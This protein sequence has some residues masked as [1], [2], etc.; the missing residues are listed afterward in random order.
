MASVYAILSKSRYDKS[1]AIP[2][3]KATKNSIGSNMPTKYACHY[4]LTFATYL[5]N[6]QAEGKRYNVAFSHTIRKLVRVFNHL[7]EQIVNT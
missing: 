2:F 5:A 4:G 6:K 3:K 1:T 7:K